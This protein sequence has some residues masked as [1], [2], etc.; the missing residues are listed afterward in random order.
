MTNQNRSEC[1]KCRVF[2]QAPATSKFEPYENHSFIPPVSFL[3]PRHARG[4]W[5]IISEFMA[6]NIKMPG[7]LLD[8]Q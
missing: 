2:A 7:A 3:I 8:R 5:P 4:D 6:F 1:E